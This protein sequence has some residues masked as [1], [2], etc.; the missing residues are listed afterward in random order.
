MTFVIIFI[1][2]TVDDSGIML[3]AGLITITLFIIGLTVI[4]LQGAK[5]TEKAQRPKSWLEKLTDLPHHEELQ[6]GLFI[7]KLN[8]NDVRFTGAGFFSLTRGLLLT[9]NRGRDH[10]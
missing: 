3:V 5:F 6:R 9:V 4:I 8:A 7:A 10:N 1:L 2:S